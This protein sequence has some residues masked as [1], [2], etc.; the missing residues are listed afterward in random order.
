MQHRF[1]LIGNYK[2]MMIYYKTLTIL[3]Q[4]VAVAVVMVS[5]TT[6]TNAI[7]GT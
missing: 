7:R 2:Q 1:V 5:P 3:L 6:T 4:I